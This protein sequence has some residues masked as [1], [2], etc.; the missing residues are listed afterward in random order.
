MSEH[1]NWMS[2]EERAQAMSGANHF[3]LVWV[4]AAGQDQ[5]ENVWPHMTPEFRLAMTQAWLTKNPRALDDPNAAA[6]NRDELAAH[7]SEERPQHQL[8]AHLARVSLREI[9]N[10]Y[11]RL[12]T[13]QLGPGLRPRP[14]GLDLELIRLFYLPDLDRD[15]AGDYVFAPGA[16]A[17][18]ANVLL[19]RAGQGW[20]VAGVGNGLL[21]PGWPPRW[22]QI[23]QP[24]D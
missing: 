23:V 24:E 4:Q 16:R 14:M 11:G 1:E 19:Q 2:P 7:L 20:A 21:R 12:D 22:E 6:S 10:S 15:E 3:A 13:D 9:R 18:A 17:R 8:F 5:I